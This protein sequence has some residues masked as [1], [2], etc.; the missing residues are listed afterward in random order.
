MKKKILFTFLVLIMCLP[1]FLANASDFTVTDLSLP[2]GV[3]ESDHGSIEITF[4]APVD[5]TTKDEIKLLKT[6]GGEIP[7]GS[8]VT[9][10]PDSMKAV[11][12][13]GRL[14]EGEYKLIGT[15]RLL[16]E[17]GKSIFGN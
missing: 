5:A 10:S 6:D 13:Y 17:E 2:G 12:V 11:L 9:L 1:A 15:E 16:S 4:S 3:I 8:Y 7:G 14:Y